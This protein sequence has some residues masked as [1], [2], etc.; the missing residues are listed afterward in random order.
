M[1][2]GRRI[3]CTGELGLQ[4]LHRG[5]II[6]ELY[7]DGSTIRILTLR[8]R[9]G[10]LTSNTDVMHGSGIIASRHTLKRLPARSI[11]S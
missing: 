8:S 10:G 6:A 3:R 1:I 5:D 11:G 2:N 7:L 4:A 9:R